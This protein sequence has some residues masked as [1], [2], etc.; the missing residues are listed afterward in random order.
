MIYNFPVTDNVMSFA[1]YFE[2][3]K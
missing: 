3:I 1:G 2:I